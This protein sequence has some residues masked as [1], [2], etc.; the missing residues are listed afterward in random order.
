MRTVKQ[1]SDLT[2]ISVRALHYYDE[3]GL[4]KPSEV[5][6]AGYRL[7]DDEDLKTLQ[8]ILFFKELDI[9]LKDVK[10]IMSSPYFDKMEAL[11]NQKKLLML[12]RKR[13]DGL[14]KL[15]NKTL[16]GESTMNF[17]EFDMSEYYNVLEEFKQEHEDKVVRIYGSVD[18]YNEFI[19]KCKSKE[20]EIA[21]MAIKQYG[22]IE[23]YAKA[24][25]KNLNSDMI[26]LSEQY[27]KFKKDFLNDKHPKLKELYKKLTTDL[28]KD[29]SSKEIQQIAEEIINIVKKDYEAF[30]MDNGDDHWYYMVQIYLVY[31][32]WIEAVDK[33]YGQGASKFIGEA[34]KNCS[35]TKQ[36]KVEELYEK[37]VSDL[38]KDPYSQEIQQI[39]EEISDESK[40]NQEVYK[41][42]EGENYW[43]YMAELY[44]S[45]STFIKVI[46]KK[47]GSGA[48]KFIGEALK[49]YSDKV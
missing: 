47:Y 5:T 46:D 8:Q 7:Y 49:F 41:V 37:L 23:K 22:S 4:L 30:K 44:L 21:K 12:K 14:I 9:P 45:N 18:K 25:K 32:E 48:S 42:D 35:K 3:I 20:D 36:P 38:S 13:L 39:V 26:N 17:K 2:G 10:E 19:E 28:S 24:V 29:P 15:I 6:E 40:K 1:V 11:K 34:L 27:D 31:P 33:K 16:K 43:G